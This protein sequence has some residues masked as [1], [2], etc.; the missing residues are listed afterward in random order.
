MEGISTWVKGNTVLLGDAAHGTVP[1]FAQGAAMALEDA[2]RLN[3]LLASGVGAVLESANWAK[4]YERA[5]VCA[6][7]QPAQWRIYHLRGLA[8]VARN[9][10][11]RLMPQGV[12]SKQLEWLYGGS[13]RF[14]G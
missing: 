5:C 7:R 13:G 1:Y 8:A 10:G 2:A 9:L 6:G 14:D 3:E 4:R 11:L 12:S